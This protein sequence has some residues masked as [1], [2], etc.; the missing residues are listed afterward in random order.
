MPGRILVALLLLVQ[1]C[2]CQQVEAVSGRV[3]WVYDGDTIE[4]EHIGRVRLLGIDTPEAKDSERDHFYRHRFQIS[5]VTLR[6]ISRQAT[7]FVIQHSRNRTVSLTFDRERKDSH[8]RILAYVYLPD[9]R[10]LN[11]MLVEKGL[12]TVFRRDEFELKNQFMATEAKARK[13]KHG[14]WREQPAAHRLPDLVDLLTGQ[15]PAQSYG[16]S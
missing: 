5:P 15:N 4:V 12:A 16:S 1:L 10:L 14:L 2:A 11:Q 3:T 9:G 6:V 7:D 8:G 13:Y